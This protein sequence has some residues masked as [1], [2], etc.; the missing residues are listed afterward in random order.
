[1]S[2]YGTLQTTNYDPSR[3]EYNFSGFPNCCEYQKR[4]DEG[5][6]S[7][8]LSLLLLV[9]IST[10]IYPASFVNHTYNKNEGYMIGYPLSFIGFSTLNWVLTYFSFTTKC[11]ETFLGGGFEKYN[12]KDYM[13][14]H[15]IE[16]VTLVSSLVVNIIW[17]SSI[18][19]QTS[20]SN[21]NTT[22]Y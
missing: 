11:N 12:P 13:C 19:L 5:R 6:C 2:T 8:P 20:S 4:D 21:S 16:V 10:I 7:S 22:I 9:N 17:L 14:C 15:F 1:M 18:I 3:H